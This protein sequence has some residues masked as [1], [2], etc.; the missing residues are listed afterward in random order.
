[1]SSLKSSPLY[2]ME[3]IQNRLNARGL[4]AG[5]LTV[6]QLIACDQLHYLGTDALDEAAS[7][8]DLY[9]NKHVLDIGSGLGGPARYLA[10]RHGCRVTGVELQED[11]FE[12]SVALT[13]RAGLG[14]LVDFICGD[15]TTLDLQGQRF[16]HWISFLAFVHIADRERLFEACARALRP[17][18][19]FYIE[20]FVQRRPFT[21]G[22][23]R[24]LAETVAC[25]YVPTAG[26][27]L[28]DLKGAGLEVLEWT[29]ATPI[30]QPWVVD[31]HER[32]RRDLEKNIE[33]H[34]LPLA[35]G[36]GHF[37]AVMRDL[38]CGGNLGGARIYGRLA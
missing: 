18:C 10:F 27:Y 19:T 8:L 6:P 15:F 34:G 17:S 37:Y 26:Q 30:W 28:S 36:L 13:E 5:P 1:M 24:A 11:F 2:Q 22:E 21:P 32:F 9:P 23:E 31:R 16:D 3:H 35:A 12:T 33:L 38:F 25:T 7:K 29:D 20:D 4:G 14:H